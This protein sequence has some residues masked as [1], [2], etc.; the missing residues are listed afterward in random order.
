MKAVLVGTC[1]WSFD[2][3]VGPVYP[4]RLSRE[5]WLS[6]Y[7]EH[8]PAVEV[9]ATHYHVPS[10]RRLEGMADRL[11][12]ANVQGVVWKAPR[13]LTHEAIPDGDPEVIQKEAK[14]FFDV[15]GAAEEKG[16]L[17]GVL[18]QFSHTADPE[19][20]LDGLD[21]ALIV[22]PP[23]PVFVEVRHAS[24]N[25][26]RY[27][28]PLR[29]RAEATGGAVVATDSPSA[30]I[31]RAFPNETA[32]FRFHG[33]NVDTWFMED[34]PGVHGSARYD[35]AYTPH[36]REELAQRVE[37]SE[38]DR[39]FAFFNNHAKGKAF[40]DA[41]ALMERLGVPPPK[42]RVTLDDF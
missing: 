41:L 20:V 13:S 18:V 27:H 9:N 4:P 36:E 12:Q 29:A 26:D 23:G 22:G 30:T 16:V 37:A 17:E 25:E 34:P 28:Q 11:K 21:D 14:A 1:G 32:Y 19:T 38:A 5:R 8:L 35:H 7:A 6:Y 10:A 15:L 2:D 24:F 39:V 31:K 33:R 42:D 40:R 3:W